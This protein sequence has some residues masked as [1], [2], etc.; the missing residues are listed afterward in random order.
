[1]KVYPIILLLLCT[2]IIYSQQSDFEKLFWLADKW[3]YSESEITIYEYWEIVNENTISGMS[4]TDKNS[5]VIYSEK[6][7]IENTADGIIYEALAEHNTSP[8]KYKLT[9][10]NDSKAVFENPENDFPQKIIYEYIEG[11]LH[12]AIEGP[13]NDGTFKKI[14]LIFNKMR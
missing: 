12:A 2:E 11:N 5:E 4:Y 13:S 1:L 9:S 7:K 6:L 8:V 14:N 10:I 3:V